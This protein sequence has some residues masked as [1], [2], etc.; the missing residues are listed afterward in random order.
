MTSAF[1]GK[2]QSFLLCATI[3]V[4]TLL[5]LSHGQVRCYESDNKVKNPRRKG[6]LLTSNNYVHQFQPFYGLSRD[7]RI[8]NRPAKPNEKIGAQIG[9]PTAQRF[10]PGTRIT[11]AKLA[12]YALLRDL[13]S[14]LQLTFCIVGADTPEEESVRFRNLRW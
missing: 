5:G 4:I 7:G 9:K 14:C 11:A 2:M 6:K 1:L 13:N 3:V 10:D 12:E 8:V